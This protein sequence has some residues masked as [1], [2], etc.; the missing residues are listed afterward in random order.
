[1]SCHS[2]K[3]LTCRT[4]EEHKTEKATNVNQNTKK[5]GMNPLENTSLISKGKITL[6]AN[7]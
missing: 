5:F 2:G 4:A 1:V 7:P 6:F 3:E